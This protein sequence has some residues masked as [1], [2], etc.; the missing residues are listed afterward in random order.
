MSELIKAPKGLIFSSV[1]W[2]ESLFDINEF[3]IFWSE[4]YGL[5]EKY[6][7]SFNPSF[8]YYQKEMGQDLKR[9]IFFSDRPFE[10]EEI[11]EAKKWADSFE[12]KYLVDSKRLINIDPGLLTLENMI[13]STG[14]PYSHRIYLGE[15]VYADLNYVFKNQ[16]FQTLEWTYPDYCHEEKIQHFNKI[17]KFLLNK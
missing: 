14:K 16:S 1:L 11:I 6:S 7:P 2:N 9:M 8:D 4:R 13:L 5:V 17:R 3:I 12:R 15:G 10:R